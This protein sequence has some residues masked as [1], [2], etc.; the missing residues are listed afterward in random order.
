[1]L[2]RD[3]KNI[4]FDI[5]LDYFVHGKGKY[6]YSE[7]FER[8]S[9]KEISAVMNYRQPVF[10]HILPNIDGFTIAQEPGYCGGI[11]NACRIMEAVHNNIFDKQNNWR[12]LE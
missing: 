11:V 8:Y 5:D 12:H 2:Q 9:D 10:Q 1:M 3:D 7:D 6:Q 4:F